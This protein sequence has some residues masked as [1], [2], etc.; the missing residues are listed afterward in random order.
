MKFIMSQETKDIHPQHS[1]PTELVDALNLVFGKQTFGRAIHAKGVVLKGKFVPSATAP[2]LSKASHL[3]DTVHVTIRFSNFAGIP[4]ISDTDTLANPRGLAIKFHLPDKSETDLITHS[5]NGFPVATVDEFRQLMI[6]IS[7]SGPNAAEPTPLV[8]YLK[9]HPIAKIFLESQQPPPVSFATLTY[10]GINSLK[11]I[12]AESKTTFGRYQIF[13]SD[14]DDF[15]SDAEI[16]KTSPN[17]LIDE[18]R[19][20]V[21]KSPIRF[22]V[23]LQIPEA[24]DKIDNPSIAW[25]DTRKTIEIG[26]LQITSAVQNNEE[27]ERELLFLPAALTEGIEPADP[28]IMARTDSYHVSYKRRHK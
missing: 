4:V 17:Y 1:T 8:Q 14:G 10:F 9:T 13:P 7:T 2:K 21:V 27:M 6:A 11:F 22:F 15:L 25:P 24:G 23:R 28:M 3:Q 26:I 5:F 12:N 19:K 20:R 16:V 18:I